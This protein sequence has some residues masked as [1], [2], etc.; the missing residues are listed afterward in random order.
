MN[1]EK[2]NL[3]DKDGPAQ[4]SPRKLNPV[5]ELSGFVTFIKAIFLQGLYH[6]IYAMMRKGDWGFTV[7]I[8][9]GTSKAHS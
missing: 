8:C 1:L 6:L 5:L 9:W 2:K 7:S 3:E 4:K